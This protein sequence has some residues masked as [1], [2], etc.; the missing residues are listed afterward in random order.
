MAQSDRAL[1][2][3]IKTSLSL[4]YSLCELCLPVDGGFCFRFLEMPVCVVELFGLRLIFVM[5]L[6]QGY[7]VANPSP[8]QT[9]LAVTNN[10]EKEPRK[11][12]WSE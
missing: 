6:H 1:K 3:I 12:A 5:T 2:T 7:G 8:S 9:S 11:Y 4:W 10:S